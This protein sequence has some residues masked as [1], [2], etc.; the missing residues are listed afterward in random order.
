MATSTRLSLIQRPMTL[1]VTRTTSASHSQ[2]PKAQLFQRPQTGAES[3]PI[4]KSQVSMLLEPIIYI[5]QCY[6]LTYNKNYYKIIC[7]SLSGRGLS[8][9]QYQIN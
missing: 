4:S 3:K 1:R 8:G 5:R 2:S 9:T 7:E 6:N